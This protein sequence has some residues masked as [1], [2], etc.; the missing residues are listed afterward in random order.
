MFLYGIENLF[1]AYR[2]KQGG[3]GWNIRGETSQIIT[4]LRFQMITVDYIGGGGSQ[5]TKKL[6]RNIW[7]APNVYKLK[8]V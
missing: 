6:L 2:F 1:N 8:R 3:L 5:K 7:T 4:V